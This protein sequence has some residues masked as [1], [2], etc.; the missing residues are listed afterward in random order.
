VATGKT[1]VTQYVQSLPENLKQVGEEKAEGI[2][3]KFDSLKASVDEKGNQL[4]DQLAQKYVANLGKLDERINEMKA[5]NRGLI[6]KAKDAIKAIIKTIIGLKD[7]LLG[8]L[9][10]AAAALDKII[11]DPIG[12]LGNL[13][14]GVKAGLS[15]FMANIGTHL[16]KGLMEWLFGALA[17]AGIQLPDT[18]DLKGIISLVLQ[19]LGLTYA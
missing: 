13:V 19:V 15:N 5:E 17:G 3:A 16:K 9:A 6:D 18:F 1:E 11:S 14:A 2:Q 7:L 8:I 12:F 4:V 10:K